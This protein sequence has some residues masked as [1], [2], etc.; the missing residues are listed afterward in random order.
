MEIKIEKEDF[1]QIKRDTNGV[2]NVN[3]LE[4]QSQLLQKRTD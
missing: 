1:I 3:Y 2:G 4:C